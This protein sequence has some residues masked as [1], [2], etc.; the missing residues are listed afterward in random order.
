MLTN[1]IFID[2]SMNLEHRKFLRPNEVE[3]IYGIKVGTLAKQRNQGFGLPY[4]IIGR[5]PKKRK[6]GIILYD[7][8]LKTSANNFAPRPRHH[9][10]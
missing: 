7:I 4:V 1:L 5:K 2:F 10:S 6:G 3:E 9:V 8:L